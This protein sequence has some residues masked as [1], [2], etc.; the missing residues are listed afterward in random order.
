M[1]RGQVVG[2]GRERHV[3]RLEL[4]HALRVRRF[5]AEVRERALAAIGSVAPRALAWEG[6]DKGG[7]RLGFGAAVRKTCRIKLLSRRLLV[8]VPPLECCGRVRVFGA[9][10]WHVRPRCQCAEDGVSGLA[11]VA[12][13]CASI[14]SIQARLRELLT[15]RVAQRTLR[16]LHEVRHADA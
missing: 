15:Q 5:R 13:S 9:E 16:W 3:G 12:A 14:R 2:I 11:R 7:D 4:A 6:A 1:D 10:R 8:Q